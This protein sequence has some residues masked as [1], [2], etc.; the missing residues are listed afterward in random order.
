MLP[1]SLYAVRLQKGSIAH[2]AKG[3][4]PVELTV[5]AARFASL[6]AKRADLADTATQEVCRTV[7]QQSY[8]PGS[9]PFSAYQSRRT[10]EARK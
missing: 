9:L 10:S 2:G 4:S 7:R 8:D 6:Y 3:D 1:Q 5:S